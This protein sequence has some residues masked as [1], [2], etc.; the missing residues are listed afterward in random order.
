MNHLR[1]NHTPVHRMSDRTALLNGETLLAG[2]TV[3]CR[4]FAERF[5]KRTVHRYA[6]R[7]LRHE[8]PDSEHA[9]RVFRLQMLRK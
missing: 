9:R 1:P 7:T 6:L 5:S 3:P 4:P 2:W 8:L